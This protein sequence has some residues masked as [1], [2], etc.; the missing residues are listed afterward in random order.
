MKLYILF[1][2]ILTIF[3]LILVQTPVFANTV[4]STKTFPLPVNEIESVISNWLSTSGYKTRHIDSGMGRIQLTP[5]NDER[6]IISL[7]PRSPL[8]T[9]IRVISASEKQIDRAWTNKLWEAISN[10]METP[11]AGLKNNLEAIPAVILSKIESVVCIKAI[12]KEQD[13]QIS[14]FVI[15]IDSCRNRQIRR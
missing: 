11:L 13:F 14:G 1:K 15:N 12:S 10:Y 5:E 7:K 9:E 6:W 3:C 2:Q 8:A 4:Y